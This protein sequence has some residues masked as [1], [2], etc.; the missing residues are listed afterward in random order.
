M[1][2]RSNLHGFVPDSSKTAVLILDLMTELDFPEGRRLRSPALSAARRIR[3]LVDRA[4]RR[5]IPVVYVNDNIGRWRSDAPSIVTCCKREESQGKEIAHLLEPQ[6]RHYFILKP[7][8]SAFFGTPLDVMLDHIGVRTLVL[9]GI[10]SHQCIL[11][12]ATDAHVR[13]YRLVIPRDCIAAP[14]PAQ[15]RFALRYFDDVL[16]AD[17]RLSSRV[18][19]RR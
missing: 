12:T 2:Q 6:A 1:R 3:T 15:T 5:S 13:D 19:L 8:H 7:K 16:S 17:T 18:V 10:S 9:T 11:F 14:S 4:D